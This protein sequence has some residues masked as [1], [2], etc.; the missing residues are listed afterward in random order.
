MIR[1]MRAGVA[2]PPDLLQ[3]FDK[4][5]KKMG[6]ASRSKAIQDAIMLF[7]SEKK[8]LS[9]TEGPQA[10]IIMILYDHETRGLE[11]TLT[12]MQHRYTD[13]INATMHV[14]LNEKECLE[15]IAV[16]GDASRVRNLSNELSSKRGVK[17]VKLAIFSQ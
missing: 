1:R 4:I 5:I 17:L 2:F 11:S 9:E 6:Y 7:V 16:R 10:G 12:H 13:T 3:D 14:H 15:T 8:H